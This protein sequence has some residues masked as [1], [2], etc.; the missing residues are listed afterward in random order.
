MSSFLRRFLGFW[1]DFL[2][3]DDWVVPVGVV[4]ALGVTALLEHNGVPGWWVLP[5]A[6]L[7]L[8]VVS[9]RRARRRIRG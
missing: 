7:G 6:V 8:L 4:C 2:V 5:L 3:G 1:L 9:V